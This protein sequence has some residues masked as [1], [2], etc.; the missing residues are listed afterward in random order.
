MSSAERTGPDAPI[1]GRGTSLNPKNRF[2]RIAYEDDPESF[3]PEA[4]PPKTEIFLDASR[5]I[6]AT[7]DSPDVGFDASI[8]PYR[9][10]SHGCVYCLAPDTPIL[11]ADMTWRPIGEARVGDA[12]LGFDELPEPGRTRKYRRAVVRGTRWSRSK[13]LRIM[14]STREVLATANHGWLPHRRSRWTCTH[15]L[16]PGHALRGM[17]IVPAGLINEP[18][19]VGY[20][21][22]LTLGDGTFRFQPG[23]RSDKLGFPAAY[24]RVA[25]ID[26]EPLVRS[27]EF[28]RSF[29][30]ETRL[31]PFDEGPSA[32]RS[33]QKVES[34][35]LPVLAKIYALLRSDDGDPD[36]QRGFLA[37]FFD[38]EGHS[39]ESLR[40]SQVAIPVLERVIRYAA[41][42][43]FGFLLEQ[44][45][46]AAST[47]RLVGRML[48]RLRFFAVCRPSIQRKIDGVLGI[49]MNLDGAAIEG[50]EPGPVIDVVDVETSTGTLFAAGLA[51]HNCYARP[52]HEMLGLSA[53]LDFETKIFAKPDAPKL[54]RAALSKPSWKPQTIAISGVTDAYQPAERRLRITRGCLEVLAEFRN[55][56]A[57]ITKNHLVTRDCDLL[58]ALA[59]HHAA[60]VF[61]S[62]TSLDGALQRRMEPRASPP[63]RRL[64]A[65]RAL[66]AAGVPVGVMVG[67][68]VP[69]LTDHEIPSIIEAAA[70]EGATHASYVVL[71]LPYAVKDLFERWLADHY[72]DRKEKVLN[73]I[74]DMRDGRLNDPRFGSRKLGEGPFADEIRGLFT[75]ARKRAGIERTHVELSTAAFRRPG[76]AQL[77]LL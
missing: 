48:D 50:V 6:I 63:E 16:R 44:I 29:G 32:R 33:L 12:L 67:P 56:V 25:L 23:W 37:G 57:I 46:N 36:Y 28:L 27:I 58:G 75:L 26:T 51:S 61:V 52:N 55:P 10:C 47:V 4:P 41:R 24:W 11:H 64:A 2:D 17:P 76:A 38:A 43:G 71:R 77:S 1:K 74:R 30:I 39:G 3:D 19:R 18:Y 70:A 53:G 35:S 42:L 7:N 45:S 54:L 40:M 66:A 68:V 62:V 22:G 73:R 72:P 59:E 31:R 15:R 69:G 20:L 13:T 34:R 14:T 65:I 5:S 49:K 60:A 8:N 21:C 9:G